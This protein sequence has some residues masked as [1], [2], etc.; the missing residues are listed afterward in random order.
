MSGELSLIA[1][2]MLATM[3]AY[4]ITGDASVY[5]AQPPTRLDSPAHRDDYALPLMQRVSVR[6]TLEAVGGAPPPVVPSDAPLTVASAA[7]RESGSTAALAREDGR[8]VGII[9]LSDLARTPPSDLDSVRVGQ[10]IS[11][12]IVSAYP[13]ETLYTAWLRM[14]RRGLRQMV[15][16]ERGKPGRRVGLLSLDEVRQVLRLQRLGARPAATPSASAAP[17]A[18]ADGAAAAIRPTDDAPSASVSRGTAPS[19]TMRETA[20]DPFG[21]LRVEDVMQRSP[22]IIEESTPL[23][24]L[25]SAVYRD[26]CALVVDAT[27]K[28][29][30][31]IVVRDLRE[32]GSS[33]AGKRLLARDIATRNIVTARRRERLRTAI[34]RMVRAGLRQLPVVD[35]DQPGAPVGLLRRTDAL[36]AFDRLTP[37]EESGATNAGQLPTTPA[38]AS[39]PS[40]R[41]ETA[42]RPQG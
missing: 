32:R 15:V 28:L 5:H 30:G 2:A 41:E 31:I 10:V 3:V 9:T 13:E 20:N 35:G 14:T 22:A 40:T 11:R 27:G 23:E 24:D 7:L 33:E 19:A 39:Q 26:G 34:R 29:A 42:A 36:S 12:E 25:R 16:V 21:A 8:I 1:P 17:T 38:P 18:G 37:H 4:V 6:E